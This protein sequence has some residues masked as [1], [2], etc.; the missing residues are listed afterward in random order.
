MTQAT[1]RGVYRC[2]HCGAE[3]ADWDGLL[4]HARTSE[5]C[6]QRINADFRRLGLPLIEPENEPGE[7]RAG[8]NEYGDRVGYSEVVTG[9]GLV[10]MLA[11]L[12]VLGILRALGVG[13]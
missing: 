11:A 6:R 9:I 12:G 8:L 4:R 3:H 1:C 2:P 7:D 13:S 10:L 5:A